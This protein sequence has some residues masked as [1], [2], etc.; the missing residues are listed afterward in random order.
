MNHFLTISDIGSLPQWLEKGS[1]L[2]T[3]PLLHK[4]VGNGRTLCLLFFNSSLR[5][6]LSTQKAARL[7]GL[8][9]W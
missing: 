7:L 8:E 5:T 3:E 1:E 2:T 4:E 6:R 9:V